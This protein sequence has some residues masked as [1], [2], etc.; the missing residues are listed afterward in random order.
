MNLFS[1]SK[2]AP[3]PKPRDPIG[4]ANKLEAALQAGDEN[5]FSDLYLNSELGEGAEAMA[6][7]IFRHLSKNAQ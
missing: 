1:I 2:P 7:V 4:L 3:A 6:R 5:A